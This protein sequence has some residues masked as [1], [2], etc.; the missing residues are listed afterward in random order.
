[1]ATQGTLKLTVLEVKN[2]QPKEKKYSLSD[3]NG[4]TICIKPD[5]KKIWEIRYTIDGKPNM[6]SLGVFPTVSL[7][8]ARLKRDEFKLKLASGSNPI[9]ERKQIKAELLKKTELKITHTFEKISRD[10]I[11]LISSEHPPRYLALKLGRLQNHIF[12]YIGSIPINEVTRMNIIECLELLKNAGKVETARRVLNIISQV[13]RYAVTREFATTNITIDIDKRYVLGKSVVKHMPTITDPNEVGRLLCLIDEYQGQMVVKCALK[14]A[15]LT[16]QRPY[17]IRFAEYS[18]FDFETN[19]WNIPANKMKMKRPHSVPITPQVKSLLEEISPY[20]QNKSP[21]LFAS[22]Y[23]KLKPI[24]D[25]TMNKALR[26]LGYGNDDLVAHGFR[27]TFS[28]LSNEN[29]QE[30]GYHTDIIERH[31]AHIDTN[32]IKGAYNH[33]E[34]WGQRVGLMTWYS[35]YLDSLK[36][37]YLLNAMRQNVV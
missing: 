29:I 13:Y 36:S 15:I 31:L 14:L 33:S 1:M 17:T 21:Y 27:G 37:Q 10:F 19:I 23:T 9:L 11:E 20:T 7:K 18:E 26:R 16:A 24:S 8:F 35:N 2:A 25:G 32:R 30:H 34:Y 6:T 12:P 22:L 4:L 28:T 3:G 5:G